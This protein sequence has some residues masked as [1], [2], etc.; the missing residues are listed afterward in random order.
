[1]FLSTFAHKEMLETM[2]ALFDVLRVH[3]HY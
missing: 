1:M 3:G 2:L